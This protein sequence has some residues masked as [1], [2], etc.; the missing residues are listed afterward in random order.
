MA[1]GPRGFWTEL[2][3]R[4]AR[5][6]HTVT[7][8]GQLEAELKTIRERGWVEAPEEIYTSIPPDR[9]PN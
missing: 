6:S 4:D 9:R 1:F 5:T 8:R 2:W 7:D 3:H